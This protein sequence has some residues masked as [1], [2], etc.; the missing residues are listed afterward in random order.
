MQYVDGDVEDLDLTDMVSLGLVCKGAYADTRVANISVGELHENDHLT[1]TM[2]GY[3]ADE[4]MEMDVV[5][6]E[7]Y[8]NGTVRVADSSGDIVEDE[9]DLD[10]ET[11]GWTR[12]KAA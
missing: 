2:P 11:L 7:V 6:D 1:L 3:G 5:I 4:E 9:L 12:T 10:L 8:G